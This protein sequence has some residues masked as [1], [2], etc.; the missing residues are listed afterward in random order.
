MQRM[1]R[2]EK[3]LELE[4]PPGRQVESA[5]CVV[6]TPVEAPNQGKIMLEM[7]IGKREN[8]GC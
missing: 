6:E 4:R 5:D 1:S 7:S 3:E 8:T 2:R